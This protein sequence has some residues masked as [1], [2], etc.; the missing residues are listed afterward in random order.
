MDTRKQD[1]RRKI[2]LGG[3]I[4]KA[5][6]A[7]EEAAVI[8]GALLSAADALSGSD[9]EAARERFQQSG[10]RAFGEGNHA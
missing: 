3:L 10:T 6:L 2:Q 1:T 5:G 8:L 4:I 9:G 7:E